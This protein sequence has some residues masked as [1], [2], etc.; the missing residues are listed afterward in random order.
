MR[1]T[2]EYILRLKQEA[3]TE[4]SRLSSL[5][6]AID[7]ETQRYNDLR[8]ARERAEDGVDSFLD[9]Q[10]KRID[11]QVGQLNRQ[12]SEAKKETEGWVKE[13]RERD[14]KSK[15]LQGELSRK[16]LQLDA[17]EKSLEYRSKKVE[18][19]EEEFSSLLESVTSDFEQASSQKEAARSL[20]AGARNIFKTIN[21]RLRSLVSFA[22][23]QNVVLS[24][25]KAVLDKK[26]QLVGH[27]E[28]VCDQRDAE[29]REKLRHIE[30]QWE[31]LLSAK[32]ALDG[33]RLP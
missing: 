18:A 13:I 24:E 26:L 31:A 30:S 32:R 21:Q 9:S 4:E 20:L 29:V 11:S 19:M 25:R 10:S 17:Q 15:A 23:E 2:P 28:K 6:A 16:S 5:R 33:K 7:R 22:E 3:L 1:P 27:R 14:K 8:T 12:L